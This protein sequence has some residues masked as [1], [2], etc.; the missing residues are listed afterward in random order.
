M[1]D[2]EEPIKIIL[3]NTGT[4]VGIT[5]LINVF[6][7]NN[8]EA[9]SETTTNAYHIQGEFKYA[10]KSYKYELWDS[11]GGQDKYRSLKDIYIKFSKILVIVYS[12]DDRQSFDDIDYWINKVKTLKENQKDDEYILALVANKWDLYKEN[13]D[14]YRKP[15]VSEEEGENASKKYKI[16]F[17]RA[18]AKKDAK[19]FKDFINELIIN[20]IEKKDPFI[21]LVEQKIFKK[22]N[23][24]DDF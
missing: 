7:G 12:I 10:N 16:V 8:F 11:G 9:D 3:L 15:Q 22:L 13:S 18:S 23:K 1:K 6:D 2:D 17:F 5:Q 20:Y 14:D 4:G 24:Y 19:S 21:I